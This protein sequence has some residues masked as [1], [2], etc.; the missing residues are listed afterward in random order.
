MVRIDSTAVTRTQI[1]WG[2]PSIRITQ[3]ANLTRPANRDRMCSRGTVAY[4]SYLFMRYIGN[5]DP[6]CRKNGGN[7]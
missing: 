6:V 5:F 4:P 1:S 2:I 7:K 3:V